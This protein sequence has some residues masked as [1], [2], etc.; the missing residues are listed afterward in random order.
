MLKNEKAA[1]G[2]I[3]NRKKIAFVVLD[4]ATAILRDKTMGYEFV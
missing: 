4:W 1:T 3:I 2:T